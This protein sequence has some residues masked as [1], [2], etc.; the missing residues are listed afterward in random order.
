MYVCWECWCAEM[1][2][3][4]AFFFRVL[5]EIFSMYFSIQDECRD[6]FDE[7]FGPSVARV[8]KFIENVETF[9]ECQKIVKK[10]KKKHEEKTP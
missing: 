2:F 8:E 5:V 9:I 10:V 6:I 4:R 7:F 1:K 3:K